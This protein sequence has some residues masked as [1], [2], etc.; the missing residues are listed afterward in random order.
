VCQRHAPFW[1]EQA[2]VEFMYVNMPAGA[3]NKNSVIP[4][5]TSKISIDRQALMRLAGTAL[6]GLQ[7]D[8]QWISL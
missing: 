8:R 2:V 7:G 1:L 5:K 6:H 4:L 3:A